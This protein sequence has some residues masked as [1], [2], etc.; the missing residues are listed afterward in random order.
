[1]N[2]ENKCEFCEKIFKT[3]SSLN[4]HKEKAKF[5]LKLQGKDTKE[6]ERNYKCNNCIKCFVS[7]KYLDRHIESCDKKFKI[8]DEELVKYKDIIEKKNKE[9]ETLKKNSEKH[10]KEY[11]KE[12]DKLKRDSEKEIEKL[13]LILSERDEQIKQLKEQNN[14]LLSTISD[15]AKQPKSNT[16]NTNNT[17]TNIKGNQNVQNV[18]SDYKTYEQ[19]TDH[20]RIISIARNNDMEKYF[21]NGQKGIAKFCVDHIAKTQDGKMIICCTDPSRKRFKCPTENNQIGEDIDARNFTKKIAE[22]IKEVCEEVYDRIQKN[23]EEQM[24]SD[25]TDYDSSFLNTKKGIAMEKY[26][27]ITNIN[28][29]SNNADYKKEISILLNV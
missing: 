14:N 8:K 18:L 24:N 1:M 26:I 9:I 22:P 12:L 6:I 17:T 21:W 10:K 4:Y 13:K 16:T 7:K 29:N 3:I 2:I 27:E 19:N 25:Q 11:E 5:C 28:D 15:I 23:I 20:D